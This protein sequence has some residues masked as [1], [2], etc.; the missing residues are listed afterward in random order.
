[1]KGPN[2]TTADLFYW[3]GFIAG[4]GIGVT[5]ARKLGVTNQ[6]VTLLIGMALGV[7]LGYLLERI[8]SGPQG[9]QDF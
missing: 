4:T 7:G 9:P 6:I 3:G 8:H 2:Y 5:L 1:M